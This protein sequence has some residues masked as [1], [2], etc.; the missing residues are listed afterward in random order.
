M[1]E[2]TAKE[3]EQVRRQNEQLMQSL[4]DEKAARGALE[5]KLELLL[6]QV[7]MKSEPERV[8]MLEKQQLAAKRKVIKDEALRVANAMAKGKEK[9]THLRYITGSYYHRKG[10]L[11]PPGTVL[12]I[13]VAEDPAIDWKPWKPAVV[14][15][16]GPG[17]DPDAIG[18]PISEVRSVN[19]AIARLRQ[20]ERQLAAQQRALEAGDTIISQV[21]PD[22]GESA[23]AQTAEELLQ[24]A[25]PQE[26][27]PEAG[28]PTRASDTDVG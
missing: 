10:T 5:A 11:Y 20:D 24:Q 28:A 18:T 16:H 4:R 1:A 21:T 25:P 3:M 2:V 15:R 14:S 8:Q 6:Q 26:Q 13:P 22:Q 19:S 27:G 12:R 23:P 17:V 9:V 7:S